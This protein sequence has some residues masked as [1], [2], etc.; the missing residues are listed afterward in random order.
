MRAGVLAVTCA[1]ALVSPLS[2]R[3]TSAEIDSRG[4]LLIH[5]STNRTVV[6]PKTRDQTT[7]SDPIVSSDGMAVGAQAEFPNCCTSYDIPLELI[8]YSRGK[9]HRFTGVDLP[10]F[11]WQFSGGSARVA[12]G[13]QTVH[14]A[15]SI[16]YELRDIA[17]E[18]LIDAADVPE[19][20]GERPNPDM[21][22]RIPAW[23]ARLR[24]AGKG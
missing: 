9:V 10:I 2:E 21:S 16:H 22:D 4:R 17:S 18:R 20:C 12:Y 15:C 5:T 8:V 11:D 3:Y 6:V 13:Q 7:F 23:V 19:A 24:A 14:F 1:L